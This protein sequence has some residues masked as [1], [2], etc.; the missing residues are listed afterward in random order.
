MVEPTQRRPPLLLDHG[1]DSVQQ[2]MSLPGHWKKRFGTEL[3]KNAI[4]ASD[5]YGALERE[6][7]IFFEEVGDGK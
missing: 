3:P 2:E 4:H 5:S 6:C 1:F 7:D